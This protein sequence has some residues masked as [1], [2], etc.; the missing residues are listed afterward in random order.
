MTL[1]F[2]CFTSSEWISYLPPSC[3]VNICPLKQVEVFFQ[4]QLI[5]RLESKTD[6]KGQVP[7]GNKI[8]HL[9]V[10][11]GAQRSGLE[12]REPVVNAPPIHVVSC[13]DV[14]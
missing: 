14:V 11:F 1:F 9:S 5:G 6:C 7:I 13:L 8:S 4:D 3:S 12:E 10:S 2:K